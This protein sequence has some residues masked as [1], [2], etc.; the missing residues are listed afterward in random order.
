[1]QVMRAQ[2]TR[3]LG[4]VEAMTGGELLNKEQKA[5]MPLDEVIRDL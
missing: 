4:E 1:M 3:L 2:A 5:M